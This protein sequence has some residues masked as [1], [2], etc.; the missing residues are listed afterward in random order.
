[1]LI[2]ARLVIF[3]L[4]GTLYEGT[5]HF[6]YYANHLK[7]KVAVEKQEDFMTEYEKMKAGNH[8]VSIGKVYDVNRD[9]ILTINPLDLFV[10]AAYK[11][12][13][14]KLG[15]EELRQLYPGA[16]QFDFEHLVAIGDGWWLPFACAKHYGVKDCYSSYLATKEYMVSDQFTI[17]KLTGLRD[18]LLELRE[19]TN[20]VLMTNSDREDVGRLLKELD[21]D[22][23][24]EH[25]ITS[26]KKPTYTK[27][28]IEHLIQQYEVKP[29]E[30]LS[31]GDNF[32][33]EIAPALSLGTKA[34][35]IQPHGHNEE[36]PNLQVIPSIT[37][38]YQN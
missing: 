3:D 22:G 15:V 35:Y 31:I 9:L 10:T 25:V 18:Y 24:F 1:M 2:N 21:L 19:K 14:E 26:A 30:V 38:C 13:G 11:W 4:D 16:Q 27:G 17:E 32:I 29:H 23:V 36:V 33:N 7:N 28:L 37:A 34:M 12:N 5:D 8:L 20:I 6:D